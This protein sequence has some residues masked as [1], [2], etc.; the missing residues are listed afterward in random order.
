VSEAMRMTVAAGVDVASSVE[1]SAGV[2][3]HEKVRRFV[4]AAKGWFPPH[5]QSLSPPGRGEQE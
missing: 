4:E 2:K 5:P 1:S 3:D